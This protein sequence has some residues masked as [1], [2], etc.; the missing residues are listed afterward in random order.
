[1]LFNAEFCNTKRSEIKKTQQTMSAVFLY[2]TD[3]NQ[4]L[5]HFFEV[6]ILYI[7]SSGVS[8]WILS[9]CTCISTWLLASGI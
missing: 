4:Y 2:L 8:T 7:F 5:F 1:M 6:C 3:R 9:T